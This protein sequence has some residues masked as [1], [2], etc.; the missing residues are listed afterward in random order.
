MSSCVMLA[1]ALGTLPNGIS[2]KPSI[3]DLTRSDRNVIHVRVLS[4]RAPALTRS[5]T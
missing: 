1:P 3:F 2:R 4:I 5:N